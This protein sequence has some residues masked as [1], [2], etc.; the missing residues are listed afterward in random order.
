[1]AQKKMSKSD[2]SELSRINLLDPP[3][4]IKKKVK[5]CKTDPQRG[6][7]FDDPERPECHNLLTLYTLLSNQ[8]KEAVAQEC[9]EMGWGQ[10]KPLLTETAIAALEPIQAKYAEILA[11]R[12]EL[13]R[14]IQA[15][16]AKASQTAQQTLARVR[17][18]LGFLAPPY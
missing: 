5:K 18:A 6:L 17:D 8:T 12:G 14:I 11:D 3:E 10:F 7:W 4:M 2:E 1:M 13:D 16:N 15:G 9:A